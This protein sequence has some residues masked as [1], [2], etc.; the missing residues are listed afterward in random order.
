M[1]ALGLHLKSSGVVAV[2]IDSQKDSL[3]LISKGTQN[4]P[5]EP[6][7]ISNADSIRRYVDKLKE[8][9]FDTKFKANEAICS[10]PQSEVFVRT[11]KVPVMKKKDLD[12]FIKYES[13]QYIPLPLEEVT[14]GYEPMP[15]DFA[16]KDKLDVLL[17]AAK[18]KA[19]E[20]YIQIVKQANL[21]PVAMEP[22]SLAMSRSLGYDRG[23]GSSEIIVDIGTNETLVILSY[24][25]YVVLTRTVPFGE[26]LL[27]KTLEQ[28]FNLDTTQAINYRDTYG[29][30]KTKAEGKVYAVLSP[31]MDKIVEEVRKSSTFFSIHNPNVRMDKIIVS[32]Q[33]ALMPGLLLYMVNNFDVEVE[34]A[35]PWTRFLMDP[36]SSQDKLI[37]EHGP[38]YTVAV[39]LALKEFDK[40]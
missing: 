29:M 10:L 31:I 18:K 21:I 28:E 14:I 40:K 3:K 26:A 33:V 39:G 34:L 23:N 36:N 25:G 8:F 19:V 32:G 2:E 17:V 7:D 27:T 1:S 24:K 11:I 35:N 6:L 9:L 13:A 22:E 37:L 38:V 16:E 12:N 4:F 15:L 30:D 5:G 20:K